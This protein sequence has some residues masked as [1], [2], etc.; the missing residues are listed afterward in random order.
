MKN[1]LFLKHL[2]KNHWP[3]ILSV[4]FF[5]LLSISYVKIFA[6][7]SPYAP[8]ATLD[9]ACAPGDANCIVQVIPANQTSNMVS[10]N[11]LITNGTN[12]DLGG[13]GLLGS[14]STLGTETWLGTDPATM[15]TAS[16]TNTVFIGI[17]AGQNATSA[18]SSIFIG[19][20]AGLNDLVD[21]VTIPGTS[22]LI[23]DNTSTG[24]F[25]NSIAI[26]AGAVNT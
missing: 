26:G 21:N 7:G 12:G 5:I 16:T 18:A 22:I 25:Q 15:G 19:N 10:S 14:T 6:I 13:G 2:L 1:T 3:R 9:P 17:N 8:G 23:G 24:G 20:N 4:I 11:G